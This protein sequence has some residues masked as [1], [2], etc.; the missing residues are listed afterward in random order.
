MRTR[1]HVKLFCYGTVLASSE[2]GTLLRR[3]VGNSGS[4]AEK[5]QNTAL[6]YTYSTTNTH[7]S[8]TFLVY[9]WYE[10]LKY[11]MMNFDS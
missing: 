11:K 8:K 3:L 5:L 4:G 2:L 6:T 1:H 7:T 9:S 10:I